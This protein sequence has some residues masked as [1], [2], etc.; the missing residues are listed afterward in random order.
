MAELVFYT[1][2]FIAHL[3]QR[4]FG[5]PCVFPLK[6]LIKSTVI[7]ASAIKSNYKPDTLF[8]QYPAEVRCVLP[9]QFITNLNGS[10]SLQQQCFLN[11]F[12]DKLYTERLCHAIDLERARHSNL[13]LAD[14]IYQVM[15]QYNLTI[16][17]LPFDTLRIKYIR[18]KKTPAISKKLVAN[19]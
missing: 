8:A 14:C 3:L 1:K 2:N 9:I 12:L 19:V 11:S 6:D 7:A 10:L 16:D 5:S 15:H 17:L 4:E 18:A 13:A